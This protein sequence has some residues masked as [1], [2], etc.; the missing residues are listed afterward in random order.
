VATFHQKLAVVIVLAAL[1]GAIWSGYSA[2][3]AAYSARLR[4]AGWVA[5][6]AIGLQAIAGSFL[7]LGGNRPAEPWHFVFG[8]LTLLALPVAMLAGRGRPPR[9]ESLIVFA[10]WLVTFGLS[11]RAVGTGGFAA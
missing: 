11:L 9:T 1:G 10:G 8:P 3:K 2:Y 6:A 5:A 7:A 4:A